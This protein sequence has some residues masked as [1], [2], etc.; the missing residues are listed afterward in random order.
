MHWHPSSIHSF[1][2]IEMKRS[3]SRLVVLIIS[4][5]FLLLY[6]IYSWNWTIVVSLTIGGL[7]ILSSYFSN[8]FERL[9]FKMSDILGI[10]IPGILLTVIYYFLLFPIAFIS[11]L[12]KN[13]PLMLSKDHRS[14]FTD[15]NKEF[16]KEDFEKTW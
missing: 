4:M 11:R 16:R 15:R 6:L 14:F 13:D 10:I 3:S 7:G 2:G 8:L 5:G 9:W 12:F 1:K